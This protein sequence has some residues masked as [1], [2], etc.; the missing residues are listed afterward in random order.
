LFAVIVDAA[1]LKKIERDQFRQLAESLSVPFAIASMRA[2]KETLRERIIQRQH[3][4]NDASEADWEVLEKLEGVQQILSVEEL[5]TTA[6]F[7]NEETGITAD[8]EGWSSL[9]QLLGSAISD[10]PGQT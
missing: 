10:V 4:A 6:H 9:H 5:V 8:S 1:F 3:A 7:A 2:N